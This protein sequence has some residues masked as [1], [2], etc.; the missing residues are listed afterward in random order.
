MP[1]YSDD[2]YRRDLEVMRKA[3][4]RHIQQRRADGDS[5]NSSSTRALREGLANTLA[6]QERMRNR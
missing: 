5:E 3:D 6:E 2:D 4:T 1:T